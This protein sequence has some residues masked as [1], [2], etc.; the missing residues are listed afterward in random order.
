MDTPCFGQHRPT[1]IR[2]TGFVGLDYQFHGLHRISQVFWVIT[3]TTL[4]VFCALYGLRS[5]LFP[6]HVAKLLR[7]N[8]VETGCLA[9][10]V[11]AFTTVYQMIVL[12]L[13]PW[14]RGWGLAAWVM[15]WVNVVAAG[16]ACVGI[17]YIFVSSAASGIHGVTPAILLPLIA[18]LTLAAG[19][20]VVCRYGE[21]GADLQ[22]PVIVLSYLFVGLGLLLSLPFDAVYLVRLFDRAYPKDKMVYQMMLFCGPPGQGSFAL[23][24]LGSAVQR[25]AFAA[26]DTS[27]FL[28]PTGA[29]IVA[30]TSQFMGILYWGYGTFWW[31]FACTAIIH[32]VY[33]DPKA[34]LRT[35]RS[36][37]SWALV[38][39]WGVYT[40]AAVELGKLL[41]SRAYWVWSTVLALL[42]VIIWLGNAFATLIGLTTGRVLGLDKGWTGKYYTARAEDEK[43]EEG[44]M[45]NVLRPNAREDTRGV[46]FG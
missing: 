20:G 8:Q 40:N 23:Q 44:N 3:F 22:V 12:N 27:T 42:L 46:A 26:Y 28:G 6:H 14:G 33:S 9:S 11:I 16:I 39:P 37:T 10:A 17:P 4:L 41:N 15:Y 2:L 24:T 36:L 19:G 29:P 7:T 18:A 35:D 30:I 43:R 13:M 32:Y 34:L 5:L 45:Q 25:G 38:F 1:E 31:A 21:L